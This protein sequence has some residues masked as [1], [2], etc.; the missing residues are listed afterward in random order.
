[1]SGLELDSVEVRFDGY[2]ALSGVSLRLRDPFFL[3]IMGPNGAGKTTL[4]KSIAGLIRVSG[5]SIRV[6]GLDPFSHRSS[7][8]L[9]VGYM[10]QIS[11]INTE[12]PLK[13]IDVVASPLRL[14]RDRRG[15]LAERV[16]WAVRVV[17]LDEYLDKPFSSLSGGLRQRALLARALVTGSRL[18]LLDEPL[19][20]MDHALRV[21]VLDTLFK[22]YREGGVSI[23]IVSHDISHCLRFDPYILLLKRRPIAFGRSME[24]LSLSNLSKAYGGFVSDRE[25]VFLGEEHG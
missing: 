24:V 5:G 10:P 22:L 1:M 20:M 8:R 9:I 2:E 19:S 13:V 12:I 17:E 7:L 6:F 23:V 15:D 18:L 21:R 3:V 16:Y 11:E 4:L 25:F 14:I